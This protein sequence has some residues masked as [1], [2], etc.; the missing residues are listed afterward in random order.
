[1]IKL[2][3]YCQEI[4]LDSSLKGKQYSTICDQLETALGELP[5]SDSLNLLEFL[6]VVYPQSPDLIYTTA[7][8]LYR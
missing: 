8:T 6:E 5:A 7:T 3:K 2:K 1:M 4:L